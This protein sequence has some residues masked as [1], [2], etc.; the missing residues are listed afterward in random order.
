MVLFF[1]RADRCA[2]ITGNQSALEDKR[3]NCSVIFQCFSFESKPKILCWRI[4]WTFINILG[5]IHTM[6]NLY[7][8]TKSAEHGGTCGEWHAISKFR[9]L[10][11]YLAPS[12]SSFYILWNNN[13]DFWDVDFKICRFDSCQTRI[14]RPPKSTDNEA[15]KQGRRAV[16]L[17]NWQEFFIPDLSPWTDMRSLNLLH[18]RATIKLSTFKIDRDLRQK[19]QVV[20]FSLPGRHSAVHSHVVS[21]LSK[22]RL[23]ASVRTRMSICIESHSGVNKLSSKQNN[24]HG[25]KFGCSIQ[26]GNHLIF[27]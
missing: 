1:R 23:P 3:Q 20:D 6:S 10:W 27:Y 22:W 18:P 13:P 24:L 15:L 4:L 11:N 14:Y 19:T 8:P 7:R 17:Q 2:E 16:N 12:P 25:S 9:K 26:L 5:I 21:R